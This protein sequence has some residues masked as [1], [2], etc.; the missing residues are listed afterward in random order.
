MDMNEMMKKAQEAAELIQKQMGE[1]QAKLDSLEVE[2]VS[3]GGLVKIR[4]TAK[5]RIL[6]VAIDDSLIVPADKQIL[7]DL[8]T[9]ALIYVH[10]LSLT[11]WFGGLFGY[12]AVVWPAIMS[13]ADGAFPRALLA[14]IAMRTAP[15]IYLG[16]AAAVMS[17]AG[18]WVMDAAAARTPWLIAYTL[19]L[20]ALV[21]NN[22]YGSVVAWPRIM[23]LPQRLV[24]REWFWFRVRMSV[25]LVVGLL[26]YSVAIITT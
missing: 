19:L 7:E 3:G 17:L 23:L 21:A 26:L 12:V 6:G 11:L 15:W 20:T 1:A 5:G 2:G 13:E 18:I 25:S 9:A 16:M 14:R 24:R 8:V 4:C 22:V 10:I